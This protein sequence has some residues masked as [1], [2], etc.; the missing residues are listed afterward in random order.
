M[1]M[2]GWPCGATLA[3][4]GFPRFGLRRIML[5]GGSILPIGASVFVSLTPES[6][7]VVAGIGSVLMGFG[8]GLVSISSLVLIQEIVERSE[9]GSATASNLFSRNLGSTLGAATLGA[10]LNY[11]LSH[12]KSVGTV[13]SDQLRQ[14]LETP[15]AL[16]D[17]AIPLALQH[18]LHLTFCVMFVVSLASVVLT[19]LVPAIPVSKLREMPA[20]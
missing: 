10:V 14:L 4:R 9:R 18:S 5:A 2:V 8:M 13:T 17:T 11:G 6:S 16:S 3:A 19:M 7:P 12:S 20:E 1:V 15:K